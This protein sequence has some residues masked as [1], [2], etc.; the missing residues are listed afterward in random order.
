MSEPPRR[1]AGQV[2]AG[3]A[4]SW[5]AVSSAAVVIVLAAPVPP[6][7]IA[8][9]R[10]GLTSLVWLAIG[11]LGTRRGERKE[12]SAEPASAWPWGRITLSGVLL[13][14]HFGLWIGSLFL[15][16]V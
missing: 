9:M 8:A 3:L 14:L 5:L 16:S 7:A 11:T 4:T 12:N 2:A 15:T 6:L 1:S 13:G 10:T